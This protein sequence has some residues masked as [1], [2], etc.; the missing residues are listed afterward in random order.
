MPSK[1][2]RALRGLRALRVLRDLM[3]PS[4]E[5]PKMFAV[6]DTRDTWKTEH[7]CD[8]ITLQCIPSVY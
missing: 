1:R 7:T 5:Y 8:G 2:D 4:S 3:G 6:K